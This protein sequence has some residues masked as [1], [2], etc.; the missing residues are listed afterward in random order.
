MGL[1]TARKQFLKPFMDATEISNNR[2]QFVHWV[3]DSIARKSFTEG[4]MKLMQ[5]NGLGFR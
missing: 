2:P 4:V 5:S 1:H 3:R